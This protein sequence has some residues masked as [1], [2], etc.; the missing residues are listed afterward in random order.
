LKLTHHFEVHEKFKLTH[1]SDVQD[2]RRVLA[3]E[4]EGRAGVVARVKPP[5]SLKNQI[6]AL[7]QDSNPGLGGRLYSNALKKISLNKR[8][9]ETN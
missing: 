7:G 9:K 1:H 6:F 3:L 8:L 2:V 5:D 4:V